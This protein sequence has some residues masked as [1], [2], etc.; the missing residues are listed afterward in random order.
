[1]SQRDE[2]TRGLNNTGNRLLLAVVI[3]LAVNF[4]CARGGGFPTLAFQLVFFALVVGGVYLLVT[5]L[6]RRR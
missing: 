5:L 1:M 3:G 6:H 2:S 4:L